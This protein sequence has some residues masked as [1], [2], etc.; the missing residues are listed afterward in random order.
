MENDTNEQLEKE[1]AFIRS[2]G[3]SFRRRKEKW[4]E[5]RQKLL[6]TAV[7]GDLSHD[8]LDWLDSV[9]TYDFYID[10]DL[11]LANQL[12]RAI[13]RGIAEDPNRYRTWLEKSKH[14][15]L[16]T[17]GCLVY[18]N[19]SPMLQSKLCGNKDVSVITKGNVI[20]QP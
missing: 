8:Y 11:D 10:D 12:A 18:V 20:K 14:W 2:L 9:H 16:D 5:N 6:D 1:L 15:K 17:N 19:E 7:K 4:E 3:E 13:E